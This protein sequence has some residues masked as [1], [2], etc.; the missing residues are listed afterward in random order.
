MRFFLFFF[1]YQNVYQMTSEISEGIKAQAKRLSCG[2]RSVMDDKMGMGDENW[3]V[4]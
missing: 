3:P 1:A 2:L 4:R